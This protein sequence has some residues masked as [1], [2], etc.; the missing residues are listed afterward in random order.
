[1]LQQ[2]EPDIQIYYPLNN[3]GT[4]PGVQIIDISGKKRHSAMT[5]TSPPIW[6]AG[7]EGIRFKPTN[8]L[9]LP[10]ISLSKQEFII[11]FWY[12]QSVINDLTQNILRFMT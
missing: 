11:S 9:E 4:I 5:S 2:F 1:M 8:F 6:E 3:K 10:I 12:M 7:N